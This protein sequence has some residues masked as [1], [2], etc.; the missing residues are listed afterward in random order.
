MI[1][2]KIHYCWLS[3]EPYPAKIRKC[4]DTWHK[5]MPDYEIKLWDTNSFDI[6][7]APV[8]VREAFEKRKWAFAADYIR[9]YALYHEGGIYLDSDVLVL[10]PFDDFLHHSFFS[11]LEYHPAQVERFAEEDALDANGFRTKEGYVTGILI[12]AAVMGAEKGSPLVKDVLEW[13]EKQCFIKTDGS[14]STDLIAPQIYA[15][16]AEKY[17]FVYKDIDQDLDG[18]IK[19]YRSEVFAG[20]RHEVT[21]ISYAIH[22]CVH[23][24]HPSVREKIKTFLKKIF[25]KNTVW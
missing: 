21:P 6:S 24:W 11:S 12:Q 9:M 4:I 10:K 15:R 5:I 3:G 17:G 20:N 14:L 25:N 18:G 23:S 19:I 2:K 22:Y 13:Y 16:E 8:Y 7:S 1:P